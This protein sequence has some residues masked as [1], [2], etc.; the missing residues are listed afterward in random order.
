[1]PEL[2]QTEKDALRTATMD[3]LND[4]EANLLNVTPHNEE[5]SL[6][7]NFGDAF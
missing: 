3:M 7:D 1:M 4:S 5:I 6:I 2:S